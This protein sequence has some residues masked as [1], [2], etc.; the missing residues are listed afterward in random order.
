M[1]A[2]MPHRNTLHV[3]P[4]PGGRSLKYFFRE[5]FSAINKDDITGRSA[6]LAY[7][8]FFAI[9]PGF[10][11]LTSLAD[12]LSSGGDGVRTMVLRHLATAVPPQAYGVL[13]EAFAR[14]EHNLGGLAFGVILSLWSATVGMSAA[15]DTLN[16]VQEVQESRPWW[17]VQVIAF[18]LTIITTV[19]VLCAIGVFFVG[20]S[21]MQLTGS[22]NYSGPLHV[23]IDVTQ[24][25]VAVVLVALVFG[26][27]YY[28]APD[29]EERQ[30][31]WIT[32]GATMGI[33]LWVAASIGLRF[34][35]NHFSSYSS[36]YGSIGAVMVLL[37][38]FYVAGFALLTGAEVNAVIED[39][40]AQKGDPKALEKGE[41]APGQAA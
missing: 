16:G 41:R 3:V 7:Y 33:L 37:L 18:V 11:F 38:W 12:M 19:L 24:W 39:I 31:H 1:A 25:T 20:D 35:V 30:W 13:Q 2:R 10:I 34:Y 14:T 15:C 23:L 9:F 22:V 36:T 26:I 28:V 40:A 4:H 17:K 29:V 27:T 32:P 5:L 6:Q 21:V 8:F